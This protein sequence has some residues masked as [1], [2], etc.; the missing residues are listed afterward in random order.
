M[1]SHR[2]F[3][4]VSL[5]FPINMMQM[6]DALIDDA[7]SKVRGDIMYVYTEY[8]FFIHSCGRVGQGKAKDIRVGLL[9]QSSPEKHQGNSRV[10]VEQHLQRDSP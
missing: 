2:P 3:Y 9:L 1:E 5:L 8:Y 7:R 4:S 10:V 6:H